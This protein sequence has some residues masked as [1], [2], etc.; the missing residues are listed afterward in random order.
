MLW[1]RLVTRVRGHFSLSGM[2]KAT[3]PA[4]WSWMVLVEPGAFV[5]ERKML[6]EIKRL[7]E[8]P[9][10]KSRGVVAARGAGRNGG[11]GP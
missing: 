7:A 4:A 10:G 5:M 3:P 8:G 2:L 11:R 6:L 1:T 9:A